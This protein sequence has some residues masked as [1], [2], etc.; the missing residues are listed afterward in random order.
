MTMTTTISFFFFFDDNSRRIWSSF[1]LRGPA[2]RLPARSEMLLLAGLG[3]HG[4]SPLP[5]E[6]NIGRRTE[7]P[8]PVVANEYDAVC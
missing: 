7:R 5:T 8:S 1:L 4:P 6:A 2:A 3:R